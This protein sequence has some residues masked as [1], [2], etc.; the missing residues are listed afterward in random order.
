MDV[1][2]QAS[3]DFEPS[4]AGS[5]SYPAPEEANNRTEPN[6]SDT[7]SKGIPKT[8]CK[9][10]RSRKRKSEREPEF[11]LRV[12]RP[13]SPT[14]SSVEKTHDQR[15]ESAGKL[16]DEEIERLI[17]REMPALSAPAQ[18]FLE[19]VVKA[20]RSE[21]S[22]HLDNEEGSVCSASQLRDERV[23]VCQGSRIQLHEHAVTDVG[24][25]DQ[26]LRPNAP[27][28]V[29]AT[30][31]YGSGQIASASCVVS[32]SDPGEQLKRRSRCPLARNPSISLRIE[33]ILFRSV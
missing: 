1:N 11:S 22:P 21:P 2:S 7:Q 25:S 32:T 5:P 33:L 16:Y 19:T 20:N 30:G 4:D 12:T 6:V 3:L 15:M 17:R 8:D 28:S 31:S 14:A 9:P 10:R 24:F 13:P 29:R 26:L 27:S 18:H 23:A